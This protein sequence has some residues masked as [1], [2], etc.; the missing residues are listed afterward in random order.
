MF[1]SEQQEIQMG[2]EADPS[3]V[4]SF[5]VYP[6][7]GL[8]RYVA[9]LGQRLA[10][11]TERPTLPWTFRVVDDPAVNAFAVP[12]GFIY[13]TRGI[14]AHMNSEAELASVLG[15]E[16]G[17]VTAR[18]SAQQMSTQQLAQVGLVAGAVLAPKLQNVLG[19]AGVGLQLLFLKFSRDDEREA[20]DLGLRYMVRGGYDASE[21]PDVYVMLDRMSAASGGDGLP[22]W[23]STHPN[24]VDRQQRIEVKLDSIRQTNGTVNQ[25]QYLRRLDG[26]VYGPNPREGFFREQEFFHPDLRF[27]LDFPAGWATANQK[28]AVLAQSPNKDALMQLTLASERSAVDAAS[29]FL[30]QEGVQGG[31]VRSS[32]INGLS[33]ASASFSATTQE[34]T[35][36]GLATF[37]EH[38][39]AVYQL[40]GYGVASTWGSYE[41]TVDRSFES[42]RVLT[43]RSALGVQ[44][45]RLDVVTLDRTLTLGQFNQRYPSRVPIETVALINGVELASTFPRGTPVKRVVGG[46]LP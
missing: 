37:V 2:L 41:S 26:L 38:G 6:D 32:S 28:Q 45:L 29:A 44:P 40:L 20:D 25:A 46:P 17:H 7:S 31:P 5:G 18:H 13:I 39:G 11:Q 4:A 35:L 9:G 33:A 12:G 30:A 16:I 21:M 43:D 1:V 15:H 8:Q 27:R 14:M 34:G 24:P 23:L 36:R 22:G 3:I 42:F 10:S 19:V